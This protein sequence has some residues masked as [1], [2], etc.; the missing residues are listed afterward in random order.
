MCLKTTL[1]TQVVTFGN[2]QQLLAAPVMKIYH[3]R[4]PTTVP[5]HFKDKWMIPHVCNVCYVPPG[6]RLNNTFLVHSGFLRLG[7]S[8]VCEREQ[9]TFGSRCSRY[10]GTPADVAQRAP[11]RD[12]RHL[13]LVRWRSTRHRAEGRHDRRAVSIRSRRRG[14]SADGITHV[15]LPGAINAHTRR[16]RPHSSPQVFVRFIPIVL[17]VIHLTLL[18]SVRRLHY[19]AR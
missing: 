16:R 6:L 10:S 2:K 14:R 7:R 15:V 19:T 5:G 8:V 4:C 9:L 13:S 12:K 17:L 1:L 11:R 18:V 3:S